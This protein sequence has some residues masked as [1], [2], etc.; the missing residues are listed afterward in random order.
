MTRW[1]SYWNKQERL[2]IQASLPEEPVEEIFVPWGRHVIKPGD[3]V[4]CFFVEHGKVHL[5]TRVTAP[6]KLTQDNKHNQSVSFVPV[7]AM[8]NILVSFECAL[9]TRQAD[10][11]KFKRSDGTVGDFKPPSPYCFQGRASLRKLLDGWDSLD[12][13]LGEP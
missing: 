2:R 9:K 7:P 12:E 8:D 3:V 10:K 1:L 5:A 11:V 4:Y 13:R 6:D